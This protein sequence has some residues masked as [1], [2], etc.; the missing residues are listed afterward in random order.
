LPFYKFEAMDLAFGLTVAPGQ[1]D[2][3]RNC[4]RIAQQSVTKAADFGHAYRLSFS[5]PSL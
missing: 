4:R 3:S 1:D 2:G 5:Q